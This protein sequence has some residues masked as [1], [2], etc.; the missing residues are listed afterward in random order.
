ML[1][2]ALSNSES[3]YHGPPVTLTEGSRYAIMYIF[4]V[5]VDGRVSVTIIVLR[6]LSIVSAGSGTNLDSFDLFNDPLGLERFDAFIHDGLRKLCLTLDSLRP[7]PYS[8]W[9]SAV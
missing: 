3:V 1:T 5:W 8:T 4:R 7:Y 9:M 2:N 6:R